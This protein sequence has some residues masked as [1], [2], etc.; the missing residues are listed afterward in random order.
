MAKETNSATLLLGEF[1]TELSKNFQLSFQMEMESRGVQITFFSSVVAAVARV[2]VAVAP[3]PVHRVE[4]GHEAV[5]VDGGLGG[6][7]RGRGRRAVG[8]R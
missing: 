5:E 2:A 4:D 1:H 6:Q 3:E 8:D 7:Q